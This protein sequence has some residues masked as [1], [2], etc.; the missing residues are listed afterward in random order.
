MEP[1][2]SD[3]DGTACLITRQRGSGRGAEAPDRFVVSAGRP[4]LEMPSA[5]DWWS[6]ALMSRQRRPGSGPSGDERLPV[7]RASAGSLV[8]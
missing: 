6:L 1:N 5:M 4:P 8:D 3:R 7:P 2:V